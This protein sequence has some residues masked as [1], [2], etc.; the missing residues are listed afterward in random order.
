MATRLL[1]TYYTA[2]T[3]HSCLCVCVV[4]DYVISEGLPSF[5]MD[6]SYMRDIRQRVGVAKKLEAALHRR[7]KVCYNFR[8]FRTSF[9]FRTRLTVVLILSLQ[10]KRETDWIQSTARALELE[11]DQ[12]W[13]GM[14][15]D[16]TGT[17]ES[18]REQVLKGDV[19]LL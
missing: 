1:L 7:K 8:H 18:D 15:T 4:S 19:L 12:D 13:Y 9:S 14:K 3:V 10:I 2:C 16:S 17:Q 6:T 5:P 11:L